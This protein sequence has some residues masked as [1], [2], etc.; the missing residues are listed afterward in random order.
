MAEVSHTVEDAS[1]YIDIIDANRHKLYEN[2]DTTRRK[3]A[4]R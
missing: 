1:L 4:L 2:T 3:E